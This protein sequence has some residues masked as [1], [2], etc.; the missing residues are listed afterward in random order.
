LQTALGN[1]QINSVQLI[2]KHLIRVARFD[3]RGPRL[4]A[5]VVFNNDVF[6]H[7]QSSDD[8]R[9]INGSIRS[10]L[11]GLPGTLKDSYMMAGLTV[12]SGSPAFQNLTAKEDAFT[13]ER[14]RSHGGIL[15]GKT[16]MPPM[17]NGGMQRG[18]YGRAENPYNKAY[19]TSAYASG[20]SNG[21]GSSTSASFA[22][23]AMAEETVSSGRSPASNNG[24][25]AYTPSR[26]VLSI[27]GNWPLFP[28]ADV[29]VP[30]ARTVGDLLEVLDVIVADDENVESDFWRGQPWV[31]LPAAS[32]VRPRDSYNSLRQVDALRGKRV[33]VP[34]MYIGEYDAEA[35]PT[36]VSSEVRAL[37]N[38]T[39]AT[40]ESL[41][42]IMEEVG[43]PLVT[44][45][46]TPGVPGWNTSYPLPG[47]SSDTTL[48]S[49]FE[50]WAYSWDDFLRMV[51][52][53][54]VSG[55]MQLSDANPALIFPQLPN[56]L[57]DRYGN[58]FGN[59]TESNTAVIDIIAIRNGTSIYDVPGLETNLKALEARRRRYL[60]DWMDSSNLDLLVWPS[61]GDVG[62]E[63]AE[64]N[65]TA[66]E[67]AWRNGVFFSN[68]NYAIRA[69]GVPTVS[70]NMGLMS[71]KQMP[72]D[73]T[74][75]GRAYD[76]NK[77]LSYGYA[78]E[79]G[80]GKRVAPP[81]TPELPTD[82][83]PQRHNR[84]LI[85]TQP[86][87]LENVTATK[88]CGDVVEISGSVNTS[89]SGGLEQLDIFIDGVAV[90][91]TVA[92]DGTWSLLA[93]VTPY[94]DPIGDVPVRPLNVP[95]Q[96]LAMIIVLA[97][98]NNG[99]SDAQLLWV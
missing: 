76:D 44:S 47:S 41:G 75:A 48:F 93:K 65:E 23:F 50:T 9:A 2:T 88:L 45:Y 67:L 38:T 3:R 82:I 51:N 54:S 55:I 35:Q 6:H 74:F 70:V 79:H 33:G 34:K 91:P 90:A 15:L 22:V 29:P 19:L 5:L 84:T 28:D 68:G 1:G 73:L 85:G 56:T 96:S 49:P 31:Q 12:A 37:W 77:L 71:K 83:I 78:F 61:V 39:R 27:R 21:A 98:A 52:D 40:L 43:F 97:T 20:S 72:V 64:T 80:H 18:L 42:A 4:N 86:P 32:S 24:L 62:P 95:D 14:L 60:E 87:C 63:D 26:G 81:L 11:E 66:A 59:R 17:A 92:E 25:V 10:A 58:S 46:E 53:S 13:V 57:P 16:N 7:A 94:D 8:F 30:Y 89:A 99:R 69:F 36:W